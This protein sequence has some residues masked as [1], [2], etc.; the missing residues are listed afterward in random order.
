MPY[1]V[2]VVYWVQSEG[3]LGS[4]SLIE[5]IAAVFESKPAVRFIYAKVA[6]ISDTESMLTDLLVVVLV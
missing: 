2:A 3:P 5:V 1:K 6:F 4:A